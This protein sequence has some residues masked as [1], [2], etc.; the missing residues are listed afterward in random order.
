M[1]QDHRIFIFFQWVESRGRAALHW[2]QYSRST[3]ISALMRTWAI[4]HAAPAQNT[5]GLKNEPVRSKF[6]G[7]GV[8]NVLFGFA[9]R[10]SMCSI[11][12]RRIC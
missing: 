10:A 5:P 8:R 11:V 7:S 3:L 2:Q 12:C 1:Q 4:V 9:V 6:P